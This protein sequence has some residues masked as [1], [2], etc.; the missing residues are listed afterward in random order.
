MD[1][2][3]Y[4]NICIHTVSYEYL[5]ESLYRGVAVCVALRQGKVS[6]SQTRLNIYKKRY[7]TINFFTYNNKNNLKIYYYLYL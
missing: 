6:T 1:V 4:N 7:R 3:N 5:Y 2:S